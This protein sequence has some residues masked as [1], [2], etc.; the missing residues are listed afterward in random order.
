MIVQSPV[1]LLDKLSVKPFFA[2]AR[3][4]PGNQ[5][6]SL[7]SGIESKGDAP[8]TVRSIEPQFLTY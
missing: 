7:A 8:D 2:D 1:G 6:N 5:K 3:F 4:V